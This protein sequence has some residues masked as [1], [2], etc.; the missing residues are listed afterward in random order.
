MKFEAITIKDIAKALNLSVS[1]VSKALRG[2]YEI[3]EETKKTVSEYAEKYNYQPNPIAQSL[4][5]GKSKS[6]GVVVC[7][8]DNIFFSQ[9]INGIE[10]VAHEKN[11]NVIITQSKESVEQEMLNVDHLASRSI[12]GLLI[13][14]SAETKEAG[15]LKKLHEKGLPIV[16]IDRITDEINTHKVIANNFKGAY[17]GTRHLIQQGFRHI[18]HLT[19]ANNL[20]IT[21]ERLEGYKKALTEAGIPIDERYI[22]FCVHGGMILEEVQHALTGLLSLKNKPDAIL[23]ASD[24][25][26]T[27]T[28][29]LLRKMKIGVPDQIA[30]VGFTNT[31]SADIFNPPLTSIVQPTM[32]MGQAATEMLIQIIESKRR[33]ERFEKRVFDT[34]LQIRDSSIRVNSEWSMINEPGYY[35]LL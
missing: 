6:I 10:S 34:E 4:K 33:P 30:L 11:Y 7:N 22:K 32:E 19:S 9:L 12:D 13:S 8:I 25:L 21:A 26:S 1:T 5:K 16:L 20:S 15:H 18:A 35:K 17:E 2:S 14:L 23:C 31:V 27:S 29:S 28:L 24:R 3:S